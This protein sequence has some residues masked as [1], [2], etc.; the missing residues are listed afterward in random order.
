MAG[1]R[2]ASLPLFLIPSWIAN[3]KCNDSEEGILSKY[4]PD[5]KK[6]D[7]DGHDDDQQCWQGV[8]A[9]FPFLFLD[10][11]KQGLMRMVIADM[12]AT[13]AT[14]LAETLKSMMCKFGNTKLF[15]LR[16]TSFRKRH[17]VHL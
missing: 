4:Q 3:D 13:A 12:I 14:M 10:S 11:L 16:Q 8:K 2:G 9:F 6:D 15:G 17:A 1:Q 5:Q 7:Q